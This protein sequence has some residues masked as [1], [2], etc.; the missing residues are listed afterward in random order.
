MHMIEKP[1]A[2]FGI[3]FDNF[4]KIVE[5]SKNSCY[6]QYCEGQMYPPGLWDSKWVKKFDNSLELINYL[7][8]HASKYNN[9]K[10]NLIQEFL[11]DFPSERKNLKKLIDK[12]R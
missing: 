11:S 8:E 2:V 3:F 12:L 1:W 9:S 5:D 7:F 4:G 6:I 10:E